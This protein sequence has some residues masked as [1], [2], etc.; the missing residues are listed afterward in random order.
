MILKKYNLCFVG[1]LLWCG[2]GDIKFVFCRECLSS[3]LRQVIFI[4]EE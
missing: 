4:R 1:I 2:G 3:A